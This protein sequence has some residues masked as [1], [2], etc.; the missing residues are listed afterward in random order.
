[1]VTVGREGD[2][3]LVVA[4]VAVYVAGLAFL[5]LVPR[6]WELNRLTVRLYI[7]FRNDVPIAPDWVLPEHYGVILNVLL[8]LPLGALLAVAWAASWWRVA[9]VCLALSVTIEVVQARWLERD[10]GWP[11]VVANT[12]GA[13]VG[14]VTISMARRDRR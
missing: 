6:G 9:L 8:F 2:R 5:V 4:I 10:G 11:D 1:V 13:L 12:V 14:V 7:L 3:R